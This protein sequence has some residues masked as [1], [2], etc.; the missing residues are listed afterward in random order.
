[1]SNP[2]R[3][4]AQ[5]D[6]P[7]TPQPEEQAPTGR[8][9]LP[10][11]P[12]ESTQ[13][14]T[15]S[16]SEITLP[17]HPASPS[18]LSLEELRARVQEAKAREEHRNLLAELE[19]L[20][21]AKPIPQMSAEDRF[22][23]RLI[24]KHSIRMP[25][26]PANVKP[27]HGN[28]TQEYYTFINRLQSHFDKHQ[29]WYNYGPHKV[30][31]AVEQLDDQRNNDW[32]AHAKAMEEPATWQDFQDFCLRL[33]NDPQSIYRDST[34]E[35]STMR[36]KQ[37]QS[38]RTFATQLDAIHRRLK[39]PYNEQHRKEHLWSKV[40]DTVRTESLKWPVEPETYEAYIGHLSMVESQLPERQKALRAQKDRNAGGG[41]SDAAKTDPKPDASLS[42]R[43]SR[44]FTPG[45]KKRKDRPKSKDKDEQ[46]DKPD[47]KRKHDDAKSNPNGYP[48]G[49]CYKCGKMGHYA[50]TCPEGKGDSQSK[51]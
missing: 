20:E 28:T 51:N 17:Q 40:I 41:K 50:D 38:V 48:H 22:A 37:Y 34:I 5:G 45:A 31:A 2:R 49:S 29:Q 39:H 13:E 8:T 27:F 46:G 10:T 19:I 33:V 9:P 11:A 43:T 4:R 12:R 35:Y 30:E 36:Q 44:P 26:E 16:S 1:M 47:K 14:T 6:I 7:A 24:E 42:S 23:L 18:Q 3:T 21:R 32:Q 25:R 15:N